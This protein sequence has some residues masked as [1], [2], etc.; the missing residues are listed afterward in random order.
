M[1]S[2]GLA[3]GISLFFALVSGSGQAA[4]TVAQGVIQFHGSIVE[5]TCSTGGGVGSTLALSGCPMFA[6]GGDISAHIVEPV[7]TVSA[8][9]HSPVKVKLVTET[10]GDGRYFD[11]QYRLNDAAGKP[12]RSGAYLVTVSYP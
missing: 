3:V 12:L 8:V 7:R 11:R 9:D 6:P 2:Q 5:A 10:T 1:S 4:T